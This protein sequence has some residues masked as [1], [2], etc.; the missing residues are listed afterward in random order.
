[1]GN[2]TFKFVWVLFLD[3]ATSSIFAAPVVTK[4]TLVSEKRISRTVFEY[5]YKITVKNDVTAQINL[6]AKLTAV[7][8]GTVAVDDQVNV[9]NLAPNAIT[10]PVD[11]F[12]IR[13]DRSLPFVSTA[14]KWTFLSAPPPDIGI[15]LPGDPADQAISRITNYDAGF[16]PP[17]SDVS[18]LTGNPPL[19]RTVISVSFK[20]GTTVG[21]INALL[22]EIGG[23]IVLTLEK[24]ALLYVR[25][26]DPGSPIGLEV[27]VNRVK[28][29]PIVSFAGVKFLASATALP[30]SVSNVPSLEFSAVD[31]HVAVGAAAAWN[32]IAALTSRS[33]SER[34]IVVIADVFGNGSAVIDNGTGLVPVGGG[35]FAMP[36]TL[37]PDKH[38]YHVAG[39]LAGRFDD[40]GS[41]TISRDVAGMFPGSRLPSV[42][43]G[44]PIE[45]DLMDLIQ[46]ERPKFFDWTLDPIIAAKLRR[47][48][49]VRRNV[50]LNTSFGVEFASKITLE[51]RTIAKLEWLQL[52]RGGFV[53]GG[54]VPAECLVDEDRYFHSA[55][56][57]N[58]EEGE[59]DF[60]KVADRN[61][62][63]NAAALDGEL[64]N[65]AVVE[66]RAAFVFSAE[67]KGRVDPG[68]LY[69][70]SYTDGNISAIGIKIADG[71]TLGVASYNW[72]GTAIGAGGTSMAAPQVAGLA[73]YL[74][75]LA[76]NLKGNQV[77]SRIRDNARPG[78]TGCIA[79]GQPVIDAYA[80]VLTADNAETPEAARVRLAILDTNTDNRFDEVDLINFKV[81]LT[82]PTPT[83]ARDYSR[84][85]LNGDGFTGGTETARFNLDMNLKPGTQ[86]SNYSTISR[87][88][89]GVT[90]SFDETKLTDEQ[91]LCYYSY[92]D[93]YKGNPTTRDSLLQ[94]MCSRPLVC[95]AS[96][97][98]KRSFVQRNWPN[99]VSYPFSH[100]VGLNNVGQA[101]GT[102]DVG[103][104]DRRATRWDADGSAHILNAGSPCTRGGELY[105]SSQANAINN[106]GQVVGMRCSGEAY[107]ATLWEPDGSFKDLWS[108]QPYHSVATSINDRGEIVG[109]RTIGF[110]NYREIYRD[111]SGKVQESTPSDFWLPVQINNV[112]QILHIR[113]DRAWVGLP[114][115]DTTL[116]SGS[117]SCPINLFFSLSRIFNDKGNIGASMNCADGNNWGVVYDKGNWR[118]LFNGLPGPR[119]AGT[120]YTV[121]LNNFGD[122]IGWGVVN[123]KSYELGPL[124]A[125]DDRV[126]PVRPCITPALLPGDTLFVSHIN[127]KGQMLA[128][129]Q[130]GFETRWELL[131][132][133]TP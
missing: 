63:W 112:G 98:Y 22:Q 44:A 33:L 37:A 111:P 24:T 126:I 13:H 60:A 38:G 125:R 42:S 15:L 18:N 103:R 83:S 23:R 92:G 75:S 78:P 117:S 41:S 106:L 11:T 59:S 30:R 67:G 123:D 49:K 2:Y 27:L 104:G 50:V 95:S 16:K 74:W 55:A 39:I 32:A 84:Y 132:P 127:D 124:L 34:P 113:D 102:W 115:G 130:T 3:L 79:I 82:S 31:H 88:I 52:I 14:L 9:G 7:G 133:F 4:I 29:K 53:G 94:G 122:A 114:F 10:T 6:Q 121:G 12:S 70:L 48:T 21:Q 85:D 91:I 129:V 101:A 26:P 46:S 77:F 56:A 119:Y 80:T 71:L 99:P 81:K 69:P 100:M 5:T 90:Q 105:F 47:Y 51:Q 108:S 68:C 72:T 45:A 20:R 35:T 96:V 40:Q 43:G 28:S 57:G 89:A 8:L 1:M 86:A 87:L 19:L 17:P 61:M 58:V 97:K 110:D 107:I 109:T 54:C 64:H 36:I 65:T 131:T 120:G 62:G 93:L 116:I 128:Q 73:A 25:I 76:P 118:R 66:N